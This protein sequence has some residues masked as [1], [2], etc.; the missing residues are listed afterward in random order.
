MRTL[1][2][3][4]QDEKTKLLSTSEYQEKKEFSSFSFLTCDLPPMPLFV[5]EKSESIIPQVIDA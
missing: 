4:T 3:Q 1:F 5:D 2:L